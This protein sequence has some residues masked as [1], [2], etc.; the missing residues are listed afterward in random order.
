[1]VSRLATGSTYSVQIKA[2]NAKGVS[3]AS[4]AVSVTL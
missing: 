1:V 3:V 2:I 4:N